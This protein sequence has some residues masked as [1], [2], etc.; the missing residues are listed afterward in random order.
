MA[1]NLHQIK[2]RSKQLTVLLG[3]RWNFIISSF[4]Q[5]VGKGTQS[6]RVWGLRSSI[7]YS[8]LADFNIHATGGLESSSCSGFCASV[9]NHKSSPAA[10]QIDGG[11]RAGQMGEGAG[12]GGA[13]Q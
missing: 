1:D 9:A 8:V 12:A 2:Y 7:E 13:G 4:E 6:P 10:C 5:G 11:S 3:Q